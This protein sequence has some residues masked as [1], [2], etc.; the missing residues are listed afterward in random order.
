MVCS[1]WLSFLLRFGSGVFVGLEALRLLLAPGVGLLCEEDEAEPFAAWRV[2][3]LVPAMTILV[4]IARERDLGRLR[5][6]ANL[7][8]NGKVL[9]NPNRYLSDSIAES[10]CF[11][12][13]YVRNKAWVSKPNER[14]RHPDTRE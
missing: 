1:F 10:K 5:F 3:D 11:L 2:D 9:P 6:V 7:D 14:C 4:A 12:R 13:R 8:G